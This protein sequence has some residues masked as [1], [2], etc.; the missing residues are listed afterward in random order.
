MI[1]VL[2]VSR[3][4]E[5][6]LNKEPYANIESYDEQFN[7]AKKE[8]INMFAEEMVYFEST[9]DDFVSAK[10]VELKDI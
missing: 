9:P 1:V 4:Y 7:L 6:D 10:L 2:E 3:I 8:A 5:I